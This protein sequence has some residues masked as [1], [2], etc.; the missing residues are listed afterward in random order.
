MVTNRERYRAALNGEKA[1]RLPVVE[2]CGIWWDKTITEWVEQG[3]PEGMDTQEL[4]AYFGLDRHDGLWLNTR[5][6]DC[7]RPAYHGAGIIKNRADYDRLHD[8]IFC[9]DKIN[10]ALQKIRDEKPM[11]DRGETP[12]GITVDGYF[13]FPRELL[14]IENH[15]FSFYDQ[16]E[17]LHRINQDL[18]D[19]SLDFIHEALKLIKPEMLCFAEDVSYNHGPMLSKEMFETFM[20]PY[21][22]QVVPVMKECGAKVMVDSDGYIEPMIPWYVD[23]GVEG[24]YPLERASGVDINRIRNEYPQFCMLQGYDKMVLMNKGEQAIRGEFERILPVMRSGWFLPGVDH[25]TPP[26]VSL[27]N[28]IL[29]VEMFFD[30]ARKAMN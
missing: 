22:L 26:G 21:Y 16:P 4:Y 3:M 5:S 1:D 15:L 24:M 13:W 6:A 30:Y 25:Q 14:G 17:L 8:K 20:K 2:W 27:K 19:F 23:V 18:V 9:R 10:M 11:H 29:Y 12:Y 28:Y 7:P